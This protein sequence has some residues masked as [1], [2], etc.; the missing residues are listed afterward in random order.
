MVFA[1]VSLIVVLAVSG[2]VLYLVLQNS[3]GRTD[4]FVGETMDAWRNKELKNA[5]F[6]VQV[7]RGSVTDLFDT[8]QR[9]DEHGYLTVDE[10][11]AAVQGVAAYAPK[12]AHKSSSG[13]NQAHSDSNQVQTSSREVDGEATASGNAD[14][15]DVS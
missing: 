5:D 12:I 4:E 11:N 9:D 7:T 8:F 14:D 6:E 2:I 10:I 15:M 3:T 1:I 13:S